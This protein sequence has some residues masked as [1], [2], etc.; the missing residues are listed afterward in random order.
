MLHDTQIDDASLAKVLVAEYYPRL[1]AFAL[2]LH[3]KP[4][5][6]YLNPGQEAI[7]KA[8]IERHRFWNETTLRAWLYRLT[9][10]LHNK[11]P[12]YKR[13]SR[14]SRL[15]EDRIIEKDEK[16]NKSQD[17]GNYLLLLLAYGHELSEDEI[18]YVMGIPVSKIHFQL[19]QVRRQV[20]TAA[21]PGNRSSIRHTKYLDMIHPAP[22]ARLTF[23]AQLELEQHLG[24]C[25]DCANY[26]DQL[27]ILE[28][29]LKEEYRPGSL[30]LEQVQYAEEEIGSVI[31]GRTYGRKHLLQPLKE[32][33]L[34]IGILLVLI[35]IGHTQRVFETY[36][37]R[38]TFTRNPTYTPVP[39]RTIFPTRT[40]APLPVELNG[41]EGEDYFYFYT[42]TAEGDTWE[43]IAAK[44]GLS[45]NLVRYLNPALPEALSSS[46][47][48]TLVGLK[49]SGLF[50]PTQLPSSPPILEPLTANSPAMEVLQRARQGSNNL[51]SL[52]LDQLFIWFGPPGYSGSPLSAYRIEIY[53][54]QPDLWVSIQSNL[55]TRSRYITYGAGDWLFGPTTGPERLSAN[56][57]PGGFQGNSSPFSGS[58]LP[59]DKSYRV[60]GEQEIIGRQA[61]M[62]DAYD[63]SGIRQQRLWVDSLTGIILKT[64]M[65]GGPSEEIIV[66]S[67]SVQAILYDLAYPED[68]FYPPSSTFL[69]YIAERK[70]EDYRT[71]ITNEILSPRPVPQE[72]IAPPPGVNISQS[73]LLLQF[74]TRSDW[75][76]VITDQDGLL[77]LQF[78]NNSS[79]E[80][81]VSV[82]GKIQV[83]AGKYY[84]GELDIEN[85]IFN[86]CQRSSD[87]WLVALLTSQD[88]SRSELS[89]FDLSDLVLHTVT[90][91][92]GGSGEFAFSPDNQRLAF[93]NCRIS[94]G[95]SIMDLETSLVERVGPALDWIFNLEWSPDGE[96]IAYMTY[97]WPQNPRV[98]VVQVST[99][100]E[101]FTGEFNSNNGKMITPGSPTETWET[102][103]PRFREAIGCMMP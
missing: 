41:F 97:R 46:S 2:A 23:D 18:A 84:L 56:W 36:N 59:V 101:V 15:V 87:G 72:R 50:H 21:F 55:E 94:C 93:A 70:L 81:T 90:E 78:H 54:S 19:N 63:S 3:G 27:L 45:L 73:P 95:L 17:P 28:Q 47:R 6:A 58:R 91:L 67:M 103:Y 66:F 85:G 83:F 1:H 60:A 42:W 52:W 30:T 61:V 4:Y 10:H 86:D 44:A 33:S 7:A 8:I 82:P 57:S 9:Y 5:P 75:E 32:I 74:P 92:A 37:A 13:L 43:S 80:G 62:L 64:E 16:G 89:W 39:T 29:S 51:S 88:R 49:S 24:S 76:E 69:Q 35:Y 22:G 25:A 77:I 40:P 100:E 38:P 26:R 68:L 14:L 12:S 79:Y 48:I 98:H 20:Y 53:A 34:V 31:A 96:Q 65:Y 99:G 11:K 102:P 71:E